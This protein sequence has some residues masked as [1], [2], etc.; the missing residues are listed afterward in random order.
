MLLI[1]RGKHGMSQQPPAPREYS[2]EEV[3]AMTDAEIRAY[4]NSNG[5]DITK[6]ESR[7]PR[8]KGALVPKRA[9]QELHSHNKAAVLAHKSATK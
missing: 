6:H 5:L 8:K 1:S 3:D 7:T 4:F 2:K 9:R